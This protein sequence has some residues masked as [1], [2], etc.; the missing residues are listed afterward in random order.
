MHV[1]V[2]PRVVNLVMKPLHLNALFLVVFRPLLFPRQ[3][4]LQQ[5]HLALQLFKKLRRFDENTLTCCQ[6]F[7]QTNV[8][9]NRMTMRGWVW[10]TNIAL[11]RDRCIP[12]IGSPQNSYLLNNKS[13]WDGSMQVNWNYSNLR[14][15]NMKVRYWVL[16]K[17]RKQQRLKL[18]KLFESGEAKPSF[19]KV[20][21]A[22]MQLFNSLLEDLRRYFAQFREFLLRL[23]QV[24]ELLNFS[25][26]L[27]LRREDVFFFNGASIYQ[28]L[29]AIAPIF[30]LPKCVIVRPSTDFH[31]LNE[32]LLLSDIRIDSI[33]VIDSQHPSIIEDLLMTSDALNVKKE[34]IEPS[35][36]ND[37]SPTTKLSGVL[38]ALDISPSRYSG[39]LPGE[40]DN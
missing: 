6:K 14:Q 8:N 2:L 24:I 28:T 11:P 32:F 1:K 31:P 39:G 18:T 34:G 23:G 33:A 36:L 22:S 16:F 10:N 12:F 20:F 3:S 37:V 19:L 30:N 25:R 40:L 35:F 21:P 29:A 17:L 38:A 4:A 15:F 27:Q 26:K 9:P 7:L 13:G 5:F